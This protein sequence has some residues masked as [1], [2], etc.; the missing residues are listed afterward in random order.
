MLHSGFTEL[1][2]SCILPP[3]VSPLPQVTPQLR[4]REGC[5]R[6]RAEGDKGV[7]RLPSNGR[8]TPS[9][10]QPPAVLNTVVDSRDT[11]KKTKWARE[12]KSKEKVNSRLFFSLGRGPSSLPYR[13]PLSS[14]HSPIHARPLSRPPHRAPPSSIHSPVHPPYIAPHPPCPSALPYRVPPSSL[15]APVH[16]PVLLSEPIK[17]LL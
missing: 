3:R 16:P 10:A 2:P 12:P 6:R 8:R 7:P 15:S 14:I 5:H 9:E 17:I 1:H 4:Q 11:I 13:A